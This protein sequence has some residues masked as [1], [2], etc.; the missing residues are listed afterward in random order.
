MKV[1]AEGFNSFETNKKPIGIIKYLPDPKSVIALIKSA[2]LERRLRTRPCGQ[3]GFPNRLIAD[4]RLFF[5]ENNLG[6][7]ID[8]GCGV[9]V[10]R[11]VR[12]RDGAK[13][14]AA[15]SRSPAGAGRGVLDRPDGGCMA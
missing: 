14:G 8:V 12:G 15:A 5:A 3:R 9:G 4:S 7:W 13:E 1:I 2:R 10:L 6:S 11:A